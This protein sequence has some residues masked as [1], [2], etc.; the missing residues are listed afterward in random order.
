[1]TNSTAST[2]IEFA[3]PNVS[4]PGFFVALSLADGVKGLG[5]VFTALRT[6]LRKRPSAPGS[7]LISSFLGVFAMTYKSPI[8]HLPDKHMR[9]VGIIAAHWEHAERI[10]ERALAG[11]ME[12]DP[13]HVGMLMV[14]IP[15]GA[16][17]DLIITHARV[18]EQRDPKTKKRSAEWDEF[19]KTFGA[20]REAYALRN[21]YV[22]ATWDTHSAPRK[23]VRRTLR[24]KGGRLDIGGEAVS[25][26]DLE[27]AA[28]TI[29]KAA[30]GFGEWCK[31]YGVE[32]GQLPQKSS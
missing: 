4:T 31:K 30:E 27:K 17:C 32:L 8:P 9:L 28:I 7:S 2:A 23:L 15:F 6:P 26:K 11:I 5:G 14:N 21:K 13:L 25:V 22:H 24:T 16:K 3:I 18:L 19:S 1:M 10:V 20:V 29:V 12:L